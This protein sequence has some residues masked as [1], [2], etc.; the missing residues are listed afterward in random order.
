MWAD[1]KEPR[2]PAG[3]RGRT[4]G[5]RTSIAVAPPPP[6]GLQYG[7][8][9]EAAISPSVDERIAAVSHGS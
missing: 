9:A 8:V 5:R 4:Q 6:P 2:R 7:Q 3:A 1:A